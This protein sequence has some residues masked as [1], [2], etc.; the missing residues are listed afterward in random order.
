MFSFRCRRLGP[1][2]LIACSMP[3]VAGAPSPLDASAAVV[4]FVHESA[5]VNYRRHVE[6][7]PRDWK[8][9]NDTVGR[10]GGWRAYAREA[11]EPAAAPAAG[12]GH[13]GGHGQ[14][15]KAAP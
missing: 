14:P 7:S 15:K 12:P 10:I 11:N 8:A 2:A 13:Q 6:T 3:A 4:P 9:T 1:V 5:F